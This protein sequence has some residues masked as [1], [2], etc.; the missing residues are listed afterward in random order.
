MTGRAVARFIRVSP[1][2][3]RYVLDVIRG[4]N[5]ER[6]FSLLSA[7]EKGAA[8]YIT[9]ALK[10][11]LD[12][13]VKKTKGE[14]DASNLFISK[15]TADCGPTLKR[16]KAGSMGR[17]MPIKKRTAHITIEVDMIRRALPAPAA[18]AHHAA[19]AKKK[20]H[21]PVKHAEKHTKKP[22]EK[23]TKVAAKR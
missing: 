20:H 22:T 15:A 21:V 18:H 3:T 13:A 17:A 23:K 11:A 19:V 12:S 16:Y 2:K 10:S 4:K 6:A 5:V 8:F 7:V 14:A 1:R 9:Q